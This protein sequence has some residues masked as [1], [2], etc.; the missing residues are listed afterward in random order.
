MGARRANR[1]NPAQRQGRDG[2]SRNPGQTFGRDSHAGAKPAPGR[3]F[4]T[5]LRA[6]N[7]STPAPSVRHVSNPPKKSLRIQTAF[8]FPLSHSLNLSLSQPPGSSSPLTCMHPALPPSPHPGRHVSNS[9][10]GPFEGTTAPIC[11][12]QGRPVPGG[13]GRSPHLGCLASSKWE[14]PPGAAN[15]RR[16]RSLMI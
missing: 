8:L 14:L 9:T 16:R 5:P 3:A 13:C 7:G 2:R 11:R 4:I 1:R 10:Y 6:P 15:A 12:V